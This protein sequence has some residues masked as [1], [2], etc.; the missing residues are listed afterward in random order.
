MSRLETSEEEMAAL[1]R[2]LQNDVGLLALI[3]LQELAVRHHMSPPT[4]I[5]QWPQGVALDAQGNCLAHLAAAAGAAEVVV[6]LLQSPAPGKDGVV[7]LS[8]QAEDALAAVND[9]GETPAM[10]AADAVGAGPTNSFCVRDCVRVCA[11]CCARVRS[12]PDVCGCERVWVI[13]R[14]SMQCV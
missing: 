9:R 11:P 12:D 13:V 4:S 7:V 5:E 6:E 10:A 1:Q 2:A 3:A 8:P 14:T